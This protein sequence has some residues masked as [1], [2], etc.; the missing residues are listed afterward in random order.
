MLRASRSAARLAAARH[1]ALVQPQRRAFWGGAFES[2]FDEHRAKARRSRL[3]TFLGALDSLPPPSAEQQEL[4]ER[5]LAAESGTASFRSAEEISTVIDAARETLAESQV[6]ASIKLELAAATEAA[7]ASPAPGS[8]GAPAMPGMPPPPPT[9]PPDDDDVEK[10]PDVLTE[11][12]QA[13]LVSMRT[14]YGLAALPGLW[15]LLPGAGSA[16]GVDAQAVAAAAA[17]LTSGTPR[18]RVELHLKLATGVSPDAP[19]APHT[20]HGPDGLARLR[21]AAATTAAST[22]QLT[23]TLLTSSEMLSSEEAARLLELDAAKGAQPELVVTDEIRRRTLLTRAWHRARSYD[24]AAIAAGD[25][26]KGAGMLHDSL[27]AM[28][29]ADV[30]EAALFAALADDAKLHTALATA[31]F[32]HHDRL[33]TR[34]RRRWNA[35]KGTGTFFALNILDFAL[36]NS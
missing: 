24:A 7:P 19:L 15:P 4:L 25:A 30:S 9:P 13:T 16:D 27:A 17:A 35:L 14:S 8:A 33:S 18:D 22:F 11:E 6:L 23:R 5:S 31:F 21:A 1:G 12:Q 10:P 20:L 29:D 3:R 28:A 34:T 36:T 26:S 2:D 32:A